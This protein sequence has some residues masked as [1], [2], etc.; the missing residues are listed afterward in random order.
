MKK[1]LYIVLCIAFT[2]VFILT[3]CSKS[4][5][6]GTPTESDLAEDAGKLVEELAAS[7]YKGAIQNHRYDF[8]MRLLTGKK[9][10]KNIWEG[11][12]TQYG[13]YVN[14]Y[15]YE[16]KSQIGFDNII[17]KTAFQNQCIDFKV[18]YKSGT[19]KISGLHYLTNEDSPAL[20]GADVPQPPEGVLEESLF[21]KSGEYELPAVL[22]TPTGEGPFPL[23]ILV[24]GSGPNNMNETVGRQSPFRDIAWGL[25]QQG[26]AV[27]RYDKR[28]LVY[29]ESF[30]E[31]STVEEETVL[32]A[33]AAFVTA[34]SISKINSEKIFILGH[35]LG[36]M[37]I[38]RIAEI[39][40]DARG[41]IM[42]GAPV[43]PLN[44]LMVMQYEYIFN[45]D[46]KLS[47][48]ERI[49][50]FQAKK[51]SENVDSLKEGSKKSASKMFN[52]SAAYWLYL[53]DY[54]VISRAMAIKRPL[55]ILQG[56]SDYQVSMDDFNA[57][58]EALGKKNNVLLI[59]YPGLGHLMTKAG[60]PP[61]PDDYYELLNVDEAVISDISQFINSN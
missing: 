15:E 60:Q 19:N 56:E 27:L 37:M 28:T 26:V 33:S 39:T 35:S 40:P 10:L 36:G 31:K 42:V 13:E 23:L 52:I 14:I 59:S 58:N 55:L 44:E 30:D 3:S 18:T 48:N 4:P 21:I 50:L 38:P 54:D 22:S 8:V 41:Y 45:L 16:Y 1:S 49:S 43:T 57:L 32:D 25:A 51:M 17:I 53:K 6:N 11:L 5:T 61:S 12:T 46:D 34:K 7:N 20:Q 2:V 47:L 29:P 9:T 24:H